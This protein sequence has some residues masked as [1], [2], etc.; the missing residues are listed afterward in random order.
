MSARSTDHPDPLPWPPVWAGLLF[1]LVATLLPLLYAVSHRIQMSLR[2]SYRAI[3]T[4][5][6]RLNA[7]VQESISGIG[8]IQLFNREQRS[9]ARFD[10]WP[11]V[12]PNRNGRI[13]GWSR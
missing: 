12:N 11:P 10:D 7:Y 6:S 8:V 3:R 1:L 5:L 13:R 9:F 4:R 2:E